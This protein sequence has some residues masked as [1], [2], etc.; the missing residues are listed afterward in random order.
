MMLRLIPG[1]GEKLLQKAED[2]HMESSLIRRLALL[3]G[4]GF[5]FLQIIEEMVMISIL[6]MKMVRHQ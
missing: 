1:F 4:N 2:L 3:P 6:Y 5:H